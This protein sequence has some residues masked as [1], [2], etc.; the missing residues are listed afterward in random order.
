M[1]DCARA[2]VVQCAA[3]EGA[4]MSSPYGIISVIVGILLIL[5]LLRLL[6]VF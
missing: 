2:R 3:Q 5:L 6:G 1:R 4:S